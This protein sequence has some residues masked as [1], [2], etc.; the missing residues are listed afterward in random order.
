MQ[1]VKVGKVSA[2]S[3][4]DALV[5]RHGRYGIKVFRRAD[6]VLLAHETRFWLAEESPLADLAWAISCV[7]STT[8]L[9]RSSRGEKR[10]SI[11]HFTGEILF[12]QSEDENSRPTEVFVEETP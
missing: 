3:P 1:C 7:L 5:G 11:A 8:Y 10:K 9:S 2:L 6:M 12:A 4:S